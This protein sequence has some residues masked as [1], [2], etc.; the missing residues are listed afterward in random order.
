MDGMFIF[1]TNDSFIQS[2]DEI[3]SENDLKETV[4]F[5]KFH[6]ARMRKLF[7]KAEHQERIQKV[8]IWSR[9]AAVVIYYL[10]R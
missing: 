9:Q 1:I 10:Y 4:S 8:T 3:P 7:V 6:E 2:L 5:S